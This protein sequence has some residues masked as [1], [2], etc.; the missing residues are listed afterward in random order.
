VAADDANMVAVTPATF[1]GAADAA[2][3]GD[4]LVLA[5]GS[6]PTFTF[7]ND[8]TE[9]S[10]I[11]IRGE[12]ADAVTITGEVR[13]DGRSYVYLENVTVEGQVKFNNATGIVV[14]GC[15]IRTGDRGIVSYLDGT[16]NGYFA[17]NI[18]LGPTA[19]ADA[20]VG[21]D[22]AN[23]GEGI[24]VTGPGNVI[25]HNYVRGFRDAIS[26]LEDDDAGLQV[27]IDI[28]G[29]D[30]EIGAD[31]AIEADFAMG[32]VRVMRNR[33]ANSF[34]G[35][36][37]QPS[38][39]GPTY[40][41]RNV[42]YNVVY[43]PFKL[44]RGSV[45]DVAL[46]NTSIKC[47][48]ALGI[49]AGATWSRA[50]FRNNV[51]I[52]GEGGGTYGGYGNGDGDIVRA[53]DADATC[54]FDY[55]GYGAIGASGFPS[56]IGGTRVDD[57]AGLRSMTTEAHAVEVDLGIFA[58]TVAFPSS[59][60]FPELLAPDLLLRDGAAAVDAGEVIGNVNDGFA[61][62]A[63]DLGAYE[64][65]S[66]LPTYG[67]RTPGSMTCGNGAREGTE[68]C[69][70]GNTTDGDGCSSA[71]RLEAL[72][73]TDGGPASDGGGRA[74]G[75]PPPGD[76]GPGAGGDDGGCGCRVAAPARS[77]GRAW[78]AVLLVLGTAALRS[79]RRSP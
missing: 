16:T 65:G 75:A 17:D 48:D 73:G 7:G 28:I 59:G 22:G 14:R 77:D 32:N 71:C 26:L 33:I 46:H 4:V 58:A 34:V 15:T 27:S 66:L 47:G 29:N 49:Y 45:G 63:P 50:L 54:S 35:L 55:D 41:I 19:W 42:M 21:A 1:D 68:D 51:F 13:L 30:I 36:S 38:L 79:R 12:S 39:G 74:D 6:Y 9:T 76:G 8:G 67:P 40:F 69:D 56:Q 10:P 78:V 72:P 2:A 18:I 25:E 43:S 20:T 52:G 37:S 24:E 57:F 62:A 60:P 23:M 70:D 11:V 64:L 44:H 61:G 53:A 5:A 3:P 31:D